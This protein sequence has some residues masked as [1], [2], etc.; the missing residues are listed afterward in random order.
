MLGVNLTV[1]PSGGGG[2]MSQFSVDV[3]A[4]YLALLGD[5]MPGAWDDGTN[6]TAPPSDG[7]HRANCPFFHPFV[8]AHVFTSLCQGN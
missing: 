6:R 1:P 4:D 7:A 8:P 5:A 2:V 3:N